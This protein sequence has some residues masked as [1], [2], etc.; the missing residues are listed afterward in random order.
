VQFAANDASGRGARG[1]GGDG[2]L[3]ERRSQAGS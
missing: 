1:E 2:Q 3:Y